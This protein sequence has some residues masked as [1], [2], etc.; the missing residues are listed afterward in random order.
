ME[1]LLLEVLERAKAYA[2]TDPH[3]LV[4]VYTVFDQRCI[5]AS[6]SHKKILGYGPD[7]LRGIHWKEIVDARDHDHKRIML[8]DAL[9]TGGSME[10]GFRLVAKS[11]QRIY[12]KVIDTLYSDDD[13][14]E[15]YV[16]CR[17]TKIGPPEPALP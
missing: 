9:L 1:T 3:A 12:V 14:S 8:E 6:P 17:T 13:H 10:I 11:G 5:W 2:S 4:E 7:E 16:I 15:N